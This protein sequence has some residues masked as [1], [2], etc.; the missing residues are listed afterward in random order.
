MTVGVI[1]RVEQLAKRVISNKELVISNDEYGTKWIGYKERPPYA[2]LV[3]LLEILA[4]SLASTVS[5]QKT[6]NEYKKL[7][8]SLG[9]EFKVLL[10]TKIEEIAKVSGTRIAEGI[11][12]VRGGDIV[13]DPGYDGVFGTVKIWPFDSAQD[14]PENE[15][16]QLSFF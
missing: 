8:D 14:K 9:G 3:P 1:H 15:K 13:V 4:E 10:E 7:T 2:M 12:R 6:I 11:N 16:E 5:S